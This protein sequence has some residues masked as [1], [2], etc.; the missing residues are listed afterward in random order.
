MTTSTA[1][2]AARLTRRQFLA[3]SAAGG[4]AIAG[5]T[6]KAPTVFAGSASSPAIL[7]GPPLR[8]RPFPR[9]PRWDEEDEKAV[10]PVLRAGVWSRDKLV[11]EAER[12]F[13]ELMGSPRCLVTCNGT[14]AII[15]AL[16]A[17]GVGPG[18]EVVTTPY[19]FVATIHPIL[20]AGALPVFVDV[21]ADMWQI[22]PAK[23]EA[24]VTPGTRVL[25]PVHILGGVCDMDRI[26]AI[27][28]RRGLKVV[29][30]ACEAHLAEWKGRKA[31]T[32]GDLGCFSFQTGKALTC[33]E[34]GAVLGRD[35]DLMDLCYSLHN[36]GR[37]RGRM[38]RDKGGY[39]IVAGKCRMAEYQASILLTQMQTV[40]EETRLRAANAEYLTARLGEIPGIVPRRDYDGVTQK[41]F[42][43]YGFRY[44][45]EAFGGPPRDRFVA[46]LSAEGIPASK[47]LGVIE[48]RPMNKEGLLD[49]A[50]ASRAYQ[51]VYPRERL[52]SYARDNECPLSDRLCEETVGFHQRL[53]LGTRED[54]DDIVSAVLKLHESRAKLAG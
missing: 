46:A 37:P 51:R 35:P 6:P 12:R 19:T 8:S 43:Y 44:R 49:H 13:A 2:E 39:P 34:G 24:R 4:A 31:G 29:E 48:S 42:Y 40:V 11:T 3:T 50:F 26:G 41:A 5:P 7:G 10:V 52:L 27:A 33:G 30:D 17:L 22:D 23:I 47:G 25:L 1:T 36:L 45:R 54:M 16:R 15:T 38:P 9:W 20:L 32:L 18:D 21:D 28:G 53:L 14:N